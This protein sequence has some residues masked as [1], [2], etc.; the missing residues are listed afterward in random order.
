M[1]IDGRQY[2]SFEYHQLP[3]GSY[4]R[5]GDNLSPRDHML[6]SERSEN[7]SAMVII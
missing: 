7:H 6:K 5:E 3:S 1:E 4:Q 2:P